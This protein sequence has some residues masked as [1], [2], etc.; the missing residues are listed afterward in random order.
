MKICLLVLL[1]GTIAAASR[2]NFQRS[3]QERAGSEVAMSASQSAL[4]SAVPTAQAA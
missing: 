2:V 1:M 3:P 4:T